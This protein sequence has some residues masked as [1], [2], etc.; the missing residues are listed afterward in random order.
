MLACPIVGRGGI[1]HINLHNNFTDIYDEKNFTINVQCIKKYL[2]AISESYSNGL[3]ELISHMLEVY[4]GD[5]WSIGKLI[6]LLG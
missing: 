5:R 2:K 1:H 6:P 3:V 4:P